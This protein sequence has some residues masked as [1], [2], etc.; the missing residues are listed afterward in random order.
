[1]NYSISIICACLIFLL[2]CSPKSDTSIVGG[3]K[4]SQHSVDIPELLDRS[5]KIQLGKEWDEV[6]N[7]YTD[8]RDAIQKDPNDYASMLELAELYIREARVTG[9]HGHYYPAAL[10]L[11]SKIT[12]QAEVSPDLKFRALTTHA[13]VQ[14]SL[15]EFS[16]A[17]KTAEKA[18]EMN[19]RNAQIYGVL[20]DCYVELGDYK[21]AVEMSDKMISIKPDIRSYS[22]ISYL[23]EIHGDVKGS[24]DALTL[25]IKAGYPGYEE[26]AWAMQTLG[27][28]Y[29]TYGEVDKAENVYKQIV[30]I[31]KDYPFAVAA[32]GDVAYERGDMELAEKKY[33]EA[34]NIIPEVGF[35]T[36]MAKLYKNQGRDEEF[37][38]IMAEVFPMLQDDVDSGHNM[39]MEYADIYK[40]LLVD[41]D[42]ALAY[43]KKEYE[44]RPDNIDV[45][46]M[47][48]EIYALRSDKD[49][50]KKHYDLA[51][52]TNSK[53]PDLE[54]I[55]KSL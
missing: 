18:V 46:R 51:I 40:N 53:H 14:L 32:L 38:K 30:E 35:Y 29:M 36:S 45:N 5:E 2:S 37:Q 22:R 3:D 4:A 48:S 6:Q 50:A 19:D 13:G 11:T 55:K 47:M 16:D 25:A 39:N 21:K 10:S 28:L 12:N 26:T 43:A 42:K 31:R 1:M 23:R 24:I 33:Q 41:Y 52:T 15:H 34:M 7:F 8:K 20:V 49:L 17:L 27:D 44:K 9:E 54:K